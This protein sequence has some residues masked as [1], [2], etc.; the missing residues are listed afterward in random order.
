MTYLHFCLGEEENTRV[1]CK[2]R[3]QNS[4]LIYHSSFI[5]RAKVS[6][7]VIFGTSKLCV[8]PKRCDAK[9]NRCCFNLEPDLSKH[10]Y[11][12]HGIPHPQADMRVLHPYKHCIFRGCLCC[13]PEQELSSS[14]PRK[15]D[16]NKSFCNKIT[17]IYF[18]N[19][20]QF[21]RFLFCVS[22]IR[23]CGNSAASPEGEVCCLC[24]CL[25]SMGTAQ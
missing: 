9:R 3:L 19:K 15:S 23:R 18:Y 17:F 12:T 1:G 13:T 5:S 25:C 21:S 6:R 10:E 14:A 16:L 2:E 11:I 4:R 8:L 24:V 7:G 22:A 20:D